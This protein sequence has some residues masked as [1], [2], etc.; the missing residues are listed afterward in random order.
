MKIVGQSCLSCGKK[1]A[2]VNQISICVNATDDFLLGSDQLK[3][4]ENRIQTGQTAK[5]REKIS[6]GSGI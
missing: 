5:R 2:W 3:L 1:E 6:L 4:Q